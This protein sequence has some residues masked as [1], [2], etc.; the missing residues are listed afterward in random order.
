MILEKTKSVS[1]YLSDVLDLAITGVKTGSNSIFVF[2]IIETDSQNAL[3]RSDDS[4][5]QVELETE[6]LVPY[7]KAEIA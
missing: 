2:E 3:L 1:T 5:E 7:L 6:Y 4:N